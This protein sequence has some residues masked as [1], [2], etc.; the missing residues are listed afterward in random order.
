MSNRVL[1]NYG[2]LP[3]DSH[4]EECSLTQ[5]I[6]LAS[7]MASWHCSS[8]PVEFEKDLTMEILK[9]ISTSHPHFLWLKVRSTNFACLGS[10]LSFYTMYGVLLVLSRGAV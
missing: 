5:N 6:L 1:I 10:C 3:Y 9:L 2:T 4:C 7:L 8:I